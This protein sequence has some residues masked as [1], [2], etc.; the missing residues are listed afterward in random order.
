MIVKTRKIFLVEDEAITAHFM[1]SQLR[2]IGFEIQRTFSCGEDVI[3]A[4]QNEEP[5]LL[6]MD[7]NLNGNIDGIEAV[8]KI[9]NKNIPVIFITGYL[10]A[11][12]RDRALEL[13]PVAYLI[14]PVNINELKD[15]IEAAL[16][17]K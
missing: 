12:V 4:V 13:S 8:K 10:N 16:E 6:L 9:N 1:K 14:K 3:V 5:D 2:N 11:E 17:E 15:S 7:I